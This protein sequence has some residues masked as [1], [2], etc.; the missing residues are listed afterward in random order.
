MN[1]QAIVSK[2]NEYLVIARKDLCTWLGKM[3]P[4]VSDDWWQTCVIDNLSVMQ[5]QFAEE[6]GYAVLDDLDLAALLRVTDKSWYAMRSFAYLPTRDRQCVRDMV[7]VRNNWAHVSGAI[8]D[9]DVVLRDIDILVAFFE[10]VIVTNKYTKS[11]V[12]GTLLCVIIVITPYANCYAEYL[13]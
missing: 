5:K 8:S 1:E 6:N 9:K 13:E 11:T 3:L 7:K 10:N 2:M 4:R 12:R